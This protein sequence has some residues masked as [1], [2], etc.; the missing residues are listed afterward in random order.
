ME[1]RQ[2][3][4]LSRCF[5]GHSPARH[6][7]WDVTSVWRCPSNCFDSIADGLGFPIEGLTLLGKDAMTFEGAG[8]AK[9]IGPV[10]GFLKN[11]LLHF[12]VAWLSARQARKTAIAVSFWT[13]WAELERRRVLSGF[14]SDQE[15]VR[16]NSAQRLGALV[17]DA[18]VEPSSVRPDFVEIVFQNY[19]RLLPAG[20]SNNLARQEARQDSAANFGVMADMIARRNSDDAVFA[21]RAESLHPLRAAEAKSIAARWPAMVGVSLRLIDSPNRETLLSD[22]AKSPPSVLDGAPPEAWAWLGEIAEAMRAHPAAATFYGRALDDGISPRGYWKVRRI[23]VMPASGT[24]A[25]AGY[26]SDVA[27][28]P[29]AR[30]ALL[31]HDEQPLRAEEVIGEWRPHDDEAAAQKLFVQ[32]RMALGRLDLEHAIELGMRAWGM[33]SAAGGM[34]AAKALLNRNAQSID[35]IHASDL[36]NSLELYLCI[37]DRL[38]QWGFPSAAPVAEAVV[39]AEL[40]RQFDKAWALTQEIPAGEATASEATDKQVLAAAALYAA[41]HG[42]Q[43]DVNR[44]MEGITDPLVIA[45]VSAFGAEGRGDQEQAVAR[46]RE[47]LAAAED[48]DVKVPILWSLAGHGAEPGFLDELAVGNPELV[49]DLRL[50]AGIR[51]R[52]PAALAEARTESTTNKRIALSLLVHFNTSG[53]VV[54]AHELALRAASRWNDADLWMHAARYTADLGDATTTISHIRAALLSAPPGWGG[55]TPALILQ[56]QQHASLD[57]WDSAVTVAEQLVGMDPDHPDVVWI[58]ITCRTGQGDTRSAYAV[59]ASHGRPRPRTAQQSMTWVRFRH[60]FGPTVGSIAETLANVAQ[61]PDDMDLRSAMLAT[62]LME[63]GDSPNPEDVDL[64]QEAMSSYFSDFPEDAPIKRIQADPE[65]LI[66][67]ISDAVGPSPDLSDLVAKLES[68]EWPLGAAAATTGRTYAQVVV[69]NPL[70]V[71]FAGPLRALE[72]MAAVRAALRGNVVIDTTALYTLTVIEE[73]LARRVFGEFGTVESTA[74]QTRDIFNGKSAIGESRMRSWLRTNTTGVRWI[75]RHTTTDIVALQ[76]H[77]A[78]A[79]VA[80]ARRTKS[81]HHPTLLSD[82]SESGQTA[83]P[84]IAGADYAASAGITFWCDDVVLKR[85]AKELGA[86]VF[87][88]PSLLAVLREDAL[89]DAALLDVSEA[90]LLADGFL[91]VEPASEVWATAIQFDGGAALG[92]ATAMGYSETLH[93]AEKLAL[94]VDALSRSTA[95]PTALTNWSVTLCRFIT[96]R[97]EDRQLA[98]RQLT[99]LVEHLVRRAWVTSATLPYI[100]AGLLLIDEN[101]AKTALGDGLYRHY[102]FLAAASSEATAVLVVRELIGGLEDS[103]RLAVMEKALAS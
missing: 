76:R 8:L 83:D 101:S 88:T 95:D 90:L 67:A 87:G 65:N 38:R 4:L 86:E 28:F 97:A 98:V 102:L 60:E 9:G 75:D 48:W 14:N 52:D 21:H 7:G 81:I 47:A 16:A 35:N 72:E 2:P 46:W 99:L 100:A 49:R 22:W 92:A 73:S 42:Q 51:R 84:W 58:L 44:A 36:T 61:Y 50:T 78:E 15:D 31:P 77:R 33:H 3:R 69:Q 11:F 29:W 41:R 82:I 62:F 74:V 25:L 39:P 103:I 12:R 79:T 93:G 34:V 68:G 32:A 57:D 64:V 5:A 96:Y 18:T 1:V 94:V 80:W 66:Q 59:W 23:Q 43:D 89:V 45:Q 24:D 6:C 55:K 13:L 26:L 54:E 10:V 70:E 19:I 20:A 85:I 27:E 30:A 71:R 37:R 91:G 63:S 40:L 56:A 53:A 17:R